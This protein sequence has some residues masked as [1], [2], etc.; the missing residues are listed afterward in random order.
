MGKK[1]KSQKDIRQYIYDDYIFN[2]EL[3]STDNVLKNISLLVDNNLATHISGKEEIYYTS[4][5]LYKIASK[6]MCK[7]NKKLKKY[8][9]RLTGE[10]NA[11]VGFVANTPEDLIALNKEGL[12]FGIYYA[13]LGNDKEDNYAIFRVSQEEPDELGAI[14]F[15]LYFIGYKHAKYKNKFF[16]L[17]EK[18]KKLRDE[19]K[20]ESIY[21]LPDGEYKD[22]QFK[23][24]DKMVFTDKEKILNYIDNW[25]ENI[26][27]YHK[28]EMTPK[29]SILLYGEPGT[30]KST[31]CRALAKHLG[32]ETVASLSPGFFYDKSDDN[33]GKRYTRRMSPYCPMVY[34]IDDIDCFCR[35]REED[36]S[37]ENGKMLASILEFL[38]SPNTFYHKAKDGIFYPISVVV[39]TTNYYDRLDAAV[40]RHG[41]FDLKVEMKPF[42]ID[43]A[44]ELCGLY[45]LKLSD[46]Y[47]DVIK[48]DFTISPAYLQALCIENLD[49][50][51]KNKKE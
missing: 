44:E 14:A 3:E 13:D 29:L 43:Q 5:S 8:K 45:D 22:V 48:K 20:E 9:R 41:R 31:F 11:R 12:D 51:F 30:G 16:N 28:Y 1:Q 36:N 49:K 50:S 35:S 21:T 25:I 42:N 39:A 17:V 4:V 40:K 23:S 19:T 47:H 33:G 10:S 24:F 46:V 26:P 2:R 37:S 18:Y 34:S 6:M 7:Y 15:D 38:D 27:V 32:I